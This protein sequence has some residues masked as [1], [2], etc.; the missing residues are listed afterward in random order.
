MSFDDFIAKYTNKPV[1]FDGVYPNQCMDLAHQ[2]V[3]DVLGITDASVLAHPAAYQVFTDFTETQYFEK[4]ENTP[5]GVPQKGDIVLFNKISSNP[6]GHVC[7]FISGDANK[8]KSFDANYPTGSLPHVQDHTYSYCLGWLRPKNVQ[9]DQQAVIN[10]LREDRDKNWNMFASLCNALGVTTS[11]DVALAEIN[12]FVGL[13]DALTTKDKQLQDATTRVQD[14]EAQLASLASVNETLKTS[15]DDSVKKIKEQSD[16]IF[17]Q[18]H[19]ITQLQSQIDDL[20]TLIKMPV[21]SGWKKQLVTF[22]AKL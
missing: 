11:V 20:K 15:N 22:L 5:A 19:S 14:L 8:F 7:I 2:Y 3:Y 13:E 6:Y 1:D 18:S 21:F 17:K 12:K 10:Q 9:Q 4:I 16:E